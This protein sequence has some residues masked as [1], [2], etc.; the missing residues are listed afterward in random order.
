MSIDLYTSDQPISSMKLLSVAVLAALGAASVGDAARVELDRSKLQRAADTMGVTALLEQPGPLS[1]ANP[2][3]ATPAD[4]ESGDFEIKC[5][6]SCDF[7]KKS[8]AVSLSRAALIAAED[9]AQSQEALRGV[10]EQIARDPLN[11]ELL[12]QRTKLELEIQEK[13]HALQVTVG[14]KVPD[15]SVEIETLS[16]EA[17]RKQLKDLNERLKGAPADP[18]LQRQKEELEETIRAKDEAIKAAGEVQKQEEALHVEVKQL[19]AK[20]TELEDA[21][22]KSPENGVLKGEVDKLKRELAEK[23]AQADTLSPKRE[24]YRVCVNPHSHIHAEGDAAPQS[25]EPEGEGEYEEP[26]DVSDELS[27]RRRLLAL[28]QTKDVNNCIR[29]C[30]KVMRMLVYRMAKQ[31]L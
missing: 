28:S 12:V 15:S 20:L 22:T 21:L 13:T 4:V 18:Q 3:A 8:A 9:L 30:V 24:C 29:M 2:M 10:V 27:G 7:V 26:N 19:R 31:F 14:A 17:A 11:R 23:S 5:S 25:D 1:G 16:I 6:T